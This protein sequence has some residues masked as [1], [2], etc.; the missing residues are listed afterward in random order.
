MCDPAAHPNGL[1]VGGIALALVG[2]KMDSPA[3]DKQFKVIIL[4]KLPPLFA[5]KQPVE[6]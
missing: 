1:K 4:E 3:R 6:V 2:E 5:V